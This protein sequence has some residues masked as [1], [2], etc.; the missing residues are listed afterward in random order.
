MSTT[1]PKVSVVQ[2]TTSFLDK[3][4]HISTK[5]LFYTT[6]Q[7]LSLEYCQCQYQGFALYNADGTAG[8]QSQG[9]IAFIFVVCQNVSCTDHT[10]SSQFGGQDSAQYTPSASPRFELV[11]FFDS[12]PGFQ[13][14]VCHTN[15]I[16][17]MPIQTY[18]TVD[19]FKHWKWRQS[20]A[21]HCMQHRILHMTKVVNVTRVHKYCSYDPTMTITP[22]S[23]PWLLFPGI[24]ISG[25][26]AAMSENFDATMDQCTE[27]GHVKEIFITSGTHTHPQAIHQTQLHG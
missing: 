27:Q 2:L 6:M 1:T 10:R 13:Y 7:A 8:R 12:K 18:L 14:L 24:F 21:A 11:A 25:P 3:I 19:R 17:L 9:R 22:A 5:N 20:V 23:M 15:F 16:N 4:P 26:T